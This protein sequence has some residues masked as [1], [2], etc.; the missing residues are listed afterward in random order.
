MATKPSHSL[1]WNSKAECMPIEERRSLQLKRLQ[2]LVERIAVQSPFYRSLFQKHGVKPG[3][4]RTLDDLRR[5]PFTVKEDLR[6]NYPYELF[7]T[8]LKDVVRIH[9]SSGTTGKPVVSGY[10]ANDIEMW[11]EMMA[12]SLT[13][14]GASYR[15]VVHNSY[16]YGLFTGGLGIDTGAR[17]IG[18]ATVPMSGGVNNRQIM[19]MED[20]GATVLTCT[21]SYALVLAEA[22]AQMGL[23]IRNRIKLRVGVFG[24]EPWTEEMRVEIEEK[25]HLEAY[26]IF[27]MGE[28]MGPGV[29][30]E[31]AYHNGLH[32][33]DDNFLPEIIDPDTGEP[34]PPG[35]QGEL[36]ITTLTKE[37]MPLIRY[38]TRDI[39]RLTDDPC[40]C[41]RTSVR[42]FKL[43]GRTDDMLIIKGVNVFPSQIEAVLLRH[44]ELAPQYVLVVERKNNLDQLEIQVEATEEFYNQGADTISLFSEKLHYEMQQMLYISSKI[45]IV[46]PRTV[47]RSEGKAK[48]VIDKRKEWLER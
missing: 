12:R 30:V 18:A 3:D 25:L 33:Q 29:S 47:Q 34:L 35:E 21:P 38:R 44:S 5:L 26:D 1:M 7:A 32:M 6:D 14:A 20:F 17:K 36:V 22:A 42:H 41:G 11:T 2:D 37:A 23:D 10:T 19:L 43:T 24:A 31:C 9:C 45:I 15:D 40:P 8:P 13:S 46:P 48:R 16:G 39:T 27:G 28:I 4:I